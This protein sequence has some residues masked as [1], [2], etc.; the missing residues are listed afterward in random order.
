MK[1]KNE[2]IVGLVVVAGLLVLAVGGYWLTGR[3][4]GGEQREIVATFQR[5]GLLA[6][7]SQ[8]KYRGVKIG[9]VERIRLAERGDGVFVTMTVNP[10]VTFP[11]DAGVLISA[12]S[13]FGDWQAEIVS[14]NSY[15]ELLWATSNVPGVF[16][17]AALPDITELT[18]VAA[19]IAT[20][21]ETLSE[22]VELA[23]TEETAIKIRET[24][25]NIQEVSEQLGG[26]VDQQTGTYRDVSQ[27]VL[28]ATAN[29]R[30]ATAAAE[31]VANDL[32]AAVNQGD[33]QA[34]LGNARAA[35]ENLRVF[36][37]QLQA[38]GQG[39]PG[40]VARADTTLGSLNQ[41]MAGI[42]PQIEQIGPTL[43]E[44]RAAMATLQRAAA[45]IEQGQGTLGRL[46]E[47]PALY[48]ETQRAVATL[49]RLLADIQANPGKYIGQF[50]VF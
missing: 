49:R 8:V 47:D 39:M 5:V 14:Q 21:I 26:F 20:D 9:R 23:F 35:S 34:V 19:R 41:T 36:S 13:F 29:I 45:K 32:G 18:A 43:E 40:L 44:A 33:I 31:R 42:Q 16:P 24:I 22:R 37:E 17:G 28:Q 30:D 50:K 48:E 15:P 11:Q 27:N 38:A 6:E 25:E 10:D 2:V 1:L 7:G 3:Q 46:V 12:E 4:W